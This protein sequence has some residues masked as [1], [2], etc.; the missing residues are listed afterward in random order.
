MIVISLVEVSSRQRLCSI[1]RTVVDRMLLCLISLQLVLEL[2]SDSSTRTTIGM[3]SL[4][5]DTVC[6]GL[7][8][9]SSFN[10][11]SYQIQWPNSLRYHHRLS[12]CQSTLCKRTATD[13]INQN[14]CPFGIRKSF[15]LP[16]RLESTG[17]WLTTDTPAKRCC[18]QEDMFWCYWR[19]FVT[20]FLFAS[21]IKPIKLE[22]RSSRY[23][24][25]CRC[26]S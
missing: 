16:H 8:C 20:G 5:G 15:F 7:H 14:R 19:S 25:L 17:S 13:G 3:H 9:S 4:R 12:K 10:F 22:C 2:S 21:H 6:P 1:I 18:S 11:R 24:V 26:V 23:S